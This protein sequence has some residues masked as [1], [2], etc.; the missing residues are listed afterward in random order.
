M[1]PHLIL[2]IWFSVVTIFLVVGLYDLLTDKA[3][4]S[5]RALLW[6]GVIAAAFGAFL[7]G[8]PILMKG[9]PKSEFQP[10]Q[11]DF[12]A[13]AV[14]PL[15]GGLAGGLV[16][17]AVIVKIQIMHARTQMAA[18]SNDQCANDDVDRAMQYVEWLK[19]RK[20]SMPATEFNE[21]YDHALDALGRA[22]ERKSESV[23]QLTP[24]IGR[25][26]KSGKGSG[27]A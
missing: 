3:Y 26:I 9:L 13:L 12:V 20:G 14:D 24:S 5:P 18:D 7:K 11:L 19:A 6:A 10:E 21:R 4:R 16:A 25:G 1:P 8:V 27:K 15:L 23:K 2:F 22:L 17:S